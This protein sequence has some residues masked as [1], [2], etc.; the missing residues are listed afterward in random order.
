MRRLLLN[1]LCWK[2]KNVESRWY[3]QFESTGEKHSGC[4]TYKEIARGSLFV[5]RLKHFVVSDDA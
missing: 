3:R 5:S 2:V 4:K 1:A